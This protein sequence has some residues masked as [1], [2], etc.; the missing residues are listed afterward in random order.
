MNNYYETCLLT[1]NELI[2]NGQTKE[3]LELVSK[4]L[5][6][7]YVP[8]PYF[9]QFNQI[10]DSIVLDSQPSSQYF[11]D[12]DE[13]G[14]ALLGNEALQYKALMSLERMNLRSLESKLR[15]WFK[16]PIIADWIKKQLLFFM[17]EQD[18]HLEIEL[19][20]N[21]QEHLLNIKDLINPFSTKAFVECENTLRDKLESHN[22][23]LLILCVSHLEQ[24]ALN[25]FPFK[26]IDINA[27]TIIDEVKSYLGE[28]N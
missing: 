5:E 10:R 13:I 11:E 8:E 14:F 17:M 9:S 19:V 4:E 23:S 22:P 21:S 24:L 26:V 6:M 28:G 7:P 15:Q 20:L 16:D 12:E 25:A 2:D 18:F 27:D 1:L 3:A